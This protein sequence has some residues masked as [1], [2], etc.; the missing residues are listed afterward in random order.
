MKLYTQE[1]I[2]LLLL[3]LLLWAPLLLDGSSLGT[4]LSLA[5]CPKTIHQQLYPGLGGARASLWC[6]WLVTL[7]HLDSLPGAQRRALDIFW[8]GVWGATACPL[9]LVLEMKSVHSPID[10]CVFSTPARQTHLPSPIACCCVLLLQFPPLAQNS[11]SS[12]LFLCLLVPLSWHHLSPSLIIFAFLKHL[13]LMHSSLYR[14][15]P[16]YSRGPSRIRCSGMSFPITISGDFFSFF[17]FRSLQLLLVRNDSCKEMDWHDSHWCTSLSYSFNA[18]LFLPDGLMLVPL[19]DWKP[20]ED[21]NPLF[22][23]SL[24]LTQCLVH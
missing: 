19:T 5:M 9:E 14:F 12:F 15:W 3:P 11:F 8:M 20:T 18:D 2:T 17:L 21:R 7:V 16:T 13:A 6:S 22:S 4:L 23:P 1:I 10:W 24:V